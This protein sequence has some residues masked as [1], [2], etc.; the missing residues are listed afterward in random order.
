MAGR[1][2]AEGSPSRVCATGT[3]G[4][5]GAG[6]PLTWD[7][8]RDEY[9]ARRR[10]RLPFGNND[11]DR[12]LRRSRFYRSRS[13]RSAVPH[14]R[15]TSTTIPVT[16]GCGAFSG[17]CCRGRAPWLASPCLFRRDDGE[18]E[19]RPP[20]CAEVQRVA[21]SEDRRRPIGEV[22]MHEWA[23]ALHGVLHVRQRRGRPRMLVVASAHGQSHAIA[24]GH[25]DAS[26]PDLYVELDG[27]ARPELPG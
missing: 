11:I 25:H 1:R 13:P 3:P 4:G 21:A 19:K 15:A 8:V 17:A 12:N 7:H 14:R 16:S 9:V 23:A 24:F 2:P 5:A 20:I 27:L 18:Q 10:S 22:V 6:G 26:R